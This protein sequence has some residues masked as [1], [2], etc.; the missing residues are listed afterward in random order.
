VSLLYLISL[1]ILEYILITFNDIK[2][3]YY[4]FNTSYEYASAQKINSNEGISHPSTLMKASDERQHAFLM[5]SH[6]SFKNT[7]L[8]SLSLGF[9]QK[10]VQRHLNCPV[11]HRQRLL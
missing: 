4:F 10:A 9:E 3:W 2:T 8:S 5:L 7:F 6:S 1:D 11:L